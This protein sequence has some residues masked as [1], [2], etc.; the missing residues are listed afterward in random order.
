MLSSVPYT[1]IVIRGAVVIFKRAWH[2]AVYVEL[3]GS[4]SVMGGIIPTS[5][6]GYSGKRV[7]C[8]L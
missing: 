5:V 3:Q 6:F 8:M 4:E 7:S 2:L 1:N